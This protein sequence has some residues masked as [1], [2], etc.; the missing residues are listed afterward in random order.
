[1]AKKKEKKT[2]TPTYQVTMEQIRGYVQQGY[3]QGRDEAIKKATDFSMAVPIIVLRDE[4]GF[5]AKRLGQFIDATHE[6]Y[7][8]IDR[9]Y[10]NLDD[11]VKTIKEETGVE[12]IRRKK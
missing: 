3:I 6:L 7:D 9:K 5:G 12:I 8:S 2:K 4:F 1:M 11:I 10:L